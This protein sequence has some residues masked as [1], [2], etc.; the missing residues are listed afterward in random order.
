MATYELN[1]REAHE[2]EWLR[3]TPEQKHTFTLTKAEESR[4][5][6]LAGLSI[7]ARAVEEQ[8][9]LDEFADRTRFMNLPPDE[10]KAEFLLT[11]KARLEDKLAQ[12]VV[13]LA[14][15]AVAAVVEKVQLDIDNRVNPI[16]VKK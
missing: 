8:R 10:Q 14:D 11:R 12:C 15:P 9:Q 2:V 13:D 7:E 16:I 3:M 6:F 4:Q 1:A 5:A